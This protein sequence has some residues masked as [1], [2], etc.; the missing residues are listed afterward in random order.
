M[1]KLNQ[2]CS[3][4]AQAQL[5]QLT[6][7]S[8]IIK[9]THDLVRNDDSN[10]MSLE[11]AQP[12]LTGGLISDPQADL[13]IAGPILASAIRQ[14]V[15]RNLFVIRPPGVQKYRIGGGYIVANQVLSEDEFAITFKPQKTHEKRSARE[16]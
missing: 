3:H 8:G 10:L 1:S 13:V 11:Y 6:L 7:C 4:S 9:P 14:V 15:E 12:P 5:G 16:L 2:A